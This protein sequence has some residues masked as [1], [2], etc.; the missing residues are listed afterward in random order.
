MNTVLVFANH[1]E[2]FMLSRLENYGARR[3]SP[4]S[5]PLPYQRS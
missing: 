4:N 5:S 3:V 1:L 2:Y